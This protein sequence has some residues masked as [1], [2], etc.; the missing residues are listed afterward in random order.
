FS[1]VY[2]MLAFTWFA[3]EFERGTKL[4]FTSEMSIDPLFSGKDCV[5]LPSRYK[6]ASDIPNIR[7]IKQ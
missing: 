7:I 5:I 2:S 3:L 6:K 1:R 4:E